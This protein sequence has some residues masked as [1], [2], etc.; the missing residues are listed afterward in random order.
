M[1]VHSV[2]RYYD[3]IVIGAGA[4]GMIAAVT[5]AE[6][7]RSVLLLEK[8]DRP[9]R[10][11]LASGNGRCNL[12][13]S[14]EFRYFGSPDFAR[15]VFETTSREKLSSFFATYGLLMTEDSEKR[16]YPLTFQSSTVVAVLRNAIEKNRVKLC[17]SSPAVNVSKNKDGFDVRTE[18]GDTF[19]SKALI[20]ACGGAAMPKLGGTF[21]GYRILQSM[22]HSLISVT[23]SLVS[24]NTD[25]RSISGLSGIRT[26]CRVMIIRNGKILH[27][28]S[29]EVLFTDYGISGICIMQ[30]AR[31]ADQPGTLVVLNLLSNAFPDRKTAE[32]EIR[33]RRSLFHDSSPVWLLNGILPEKISFAVLKQAGFALRGETAGET[34][35]AAIGRILEAA[36]GYRITVT[37]IR[38]LDQAQVTA[39]GIDCGEFNPYTMESLLVHRLF[40]AGEVLN[41]DGD[42]GGFNLMFAFASGMTAGNAV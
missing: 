35:D 9:G 16:I 37:G 6:R 22:G 38:G 10:K 3:V 40:A 25:S 31:Y 5:A 20:I 8:S 28:E 15:K 12:M 7:M 2:T 29:G 42:C 13:N 33:R 18:A 19:R 11:I 1:K 34:D 27:S 14:G 24:M 30:C 23:P 21:D 41:V 17:P 36:Y 4:A 26:R 32:E 39:G